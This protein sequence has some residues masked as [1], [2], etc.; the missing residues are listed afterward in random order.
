[1]L[2]RLLAQTPLPLTRDVT[3][4]Q[5]NQRLE[6][7]WVS[8][9]RRVA[10]NVCQEKKK[11]EKTK[12]I[13]DSRLFRVHAALSVSLRIPAGKKMSAECQNPNLRKSHLLSEDGWAAER[14]CACLSSVLPL[15]GDAGRGRRAGKGGR[16]VSTG[17]C[18]PPEGTKQEQGRKKKGKSDFFFSF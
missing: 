14:S 6:T 12:G 10:K 17:V 16:R 5:S 2:L 18:K 9:A 11:P 1:M 7:V 3:V 13:K 4:I 8:S 15:S